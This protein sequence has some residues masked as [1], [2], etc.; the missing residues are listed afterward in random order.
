MGRRLSASISGLD[1]MNPAD[2]SEGH[3]FLLQLHKRTKAIAADLRSV[4]FLDLFFFF[5]FVMLYPFNGG[6]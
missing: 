3:S 4:M 1:R 6:I 5:L 2:S